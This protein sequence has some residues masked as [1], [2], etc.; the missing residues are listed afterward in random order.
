MPNR[1]ATVLAGA[2]ALSMATAGIVA[3]D[4]VDG[5]ADIVISGTQS[6]INLGTV[7][8]GSTHTLDFGFDLVCKG[9][10]HV[11]VGTTIDLTPAPTAPAG[12]TIDATPASVGPVPDSWPGAGEACIGD[13]VLPATVRSHVTIVAP[14]AAGSNYIYRVAFT[15]SPSGGTSGTTMAQVALSVAANA[16]PELDLPADMNVEGNATGGWLGTWAATATDAEDVTDPVACD[17]ASGSLFPLGTTTVSCSATDSGGL[18]ANGAFTVHVV[19]TTA[20]ALGALPSPSAS[21]TDPA[22]ATV[23]WTKPTADDLVDPS[24]SVDCLPASGSTFPIGT[25]NVICT[26]TDA[27]GNGVSG[28]FDVTVSLDDPLPPPPN[29]PSFS[30]SWGAPVGHAWTVARLGR[31]LPVKV[32][33]R[34]DGKRLGPDGGQAAPTLRADDLGACRLDAGVTGSVALGALHWT[35]GRWMA[36]VD[37]GHLTVGCWRLVVVVDGTDAGGAGLRLFDNHHALGHERRSHPQHPAGHR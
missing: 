23:S 8:G 19:D 20:P 31:S 4:S 3:A 29:P 12:G 10:S 9:T 7:A 15:R 25:T 16:A 17:P 27:S 2:V 24:P 35:G 11:P 37:T 28:S 21:T 14:L 13:P 6:L 34:A 1:I 33:I 5:D 18:T 26:A 32:D 36:V 30:V 22:G